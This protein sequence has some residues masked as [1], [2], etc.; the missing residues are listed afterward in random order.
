MSKNKEI[1]HLK[2]IKISHISLHLFP[3]IFFVKKSL[4]LK[5]VTTETILYL[6]N[7]IFHMEH[8]ERI[9]SKGKW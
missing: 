4:L 7:Y 9:S 5:T 6:N 3:L 2:V 1:A 8:F